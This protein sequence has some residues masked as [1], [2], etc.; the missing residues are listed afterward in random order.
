[1]NSEDEHRGKMLKVRLGDGITLLYSSLPGK[2]TKATYSP[3]IFFVDVSFTYPS[4]YYADFKAIR[5]YI[6]HRMKQELR[7]KFAFYLLSVSVP[8]GFKSKS[9]KRMFV[10]LNISLK[11]NEPYQD[12]R[13]L[14]WLNELMRGIYD[15]IVTRFLS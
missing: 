3:E 2:N 12:F 10:T 13:K 5:R 11:Q 6:E 8:E 1:M 15:E 14:E 9:S 7:Q 4:N